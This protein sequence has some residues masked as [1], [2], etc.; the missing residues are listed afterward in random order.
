MIVELLGPPGAGKS[1]LL[2]AAIDAVGR[3][4]GRPCRS[5]SDAVDDQL[6][7]SPAGRLLAPLFGGRPRRLRALLVDLPY[8]VGFMV[9][10]P[11]PALAAIRAILR[12]PV[13]WGHR[14]T[15]LMRW[16]GVAARQRFLRGRLGDE[17]A[18]FDEGLYHRSVNLFA[19][20]RGDPRRLAARRAELRGYLRAVPAPDVA[21]F[22]DAPDGVTGARL[23]SRGLPLRLRGHP[24]R[25]VAAFLLAAGEIART[26][27]E[28]TGDLARWV[29]VENVSTL[30]DAAR[31]LDA[32]L[33]QLGHAPRAA[34]SGGWPVA[35]VH[36]FPPIRRVDRWWRNRPR[37]LATGQRRV[38][39]DVS[40]ALGVGHI[41]AARSVGAGR[42]WNVVMETD[43]GRLVMKRYKPSV[44]DAAVAS[45]HWVLQR[46]AE[47]ALPTPRLV[48]GPD[49]ATIVRRADRA[50]ALFDHI[51]G[52]LP[53]HE[54]VTV[55][56]ERRRLARGAGSLLAI[57]HEALAN[58][59]PAA[60][61]STGL[62]PD[63][64]RQLPS[65]GQSD[66]LRRAAAALSASPRATATFAERLCRLD[67]QLAGSSLRTTLVHGDYG[68][69]NLLL[70]SGRP[71]VVIDFELARLDWRL[72]DVVT[73]APRFSVARTGF[74][75]DRFAAF[76]AG[77][78]ELAPEMR[79]ELALAPVLLEL[80]SLRRAA[81]LLGRDAQQ[82][83]RAL[84]RQ[85]AERL[86]A[87][88]A[89]AD[90]SH[91]LIGPFSRAAQ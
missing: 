24:P 35:A 64:S 87:A 27:P 11:R 77:Y 15:L 25:R 66:Q 85:A 23:A 6:R 72:L 61:P 79:G 34:P 8:G 47:L 29:R 75:A 76:L 88:R 43:R 21:I 48:A 62:G 65:A 50:F 58:V 83:D 46:L 17:I 78:L 14:W 26:V 90:G 49:G 56:A 2:P 80:L 4:S 36:R 41:R 53:M 28:E 13:G 74:S 7:R 57:L 54:L 63:G 18:V 51:D 42:S 19:W 32:G 37:S 59:P 30:D 31:Q 91:P 10:R 70:R 22:V 33:H 20:R 3:W 38:V 16:G 89:L 69:Y 86:V 71:L 60:Y 84:V 68:P 9:S 81:I 67:A 1:A 52:H 12:A 5:A 40:A 73:A 82:P 55:P 45:E 44:E 39:E